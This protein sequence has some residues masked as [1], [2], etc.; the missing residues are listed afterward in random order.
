MTEPRVHISASPH[1]HSKHSKSIS[2]IMLWVVIALLP[3]TIWGII[4]FGIK[5][6]LVV[7]VSVVTAVVVEMLCDLL[8]KRSI[9]SIKDFSAVVTGLLVGLNLSSEV[10]LYVAI[11]AS[12]FAIAVCKMVFGGIGQNF[13]NPA[14][15]G[16]AFVMFS[17]TSLVNQYATPLLLQS[18]A[19]ADG[20]LLSGS[21][22]LSYFKNL[23]KTAATPVSSLIDS[24]YPFTD[25]AA[26]V[27][28]IFGINPYYV[29][30]F[31]G[32]IGGSIGEVSALFILVGAA[33]LFVKKIITWRIPVMYI[34]SF[35]ILTWIFGGVPQGAGLFTGD[36]IWGVLT[37]GLLLGAFFMATDMV[38]TPMSN[39][40]H[41]IFG[42]GC[43]FFT[44][45]FR[46]F[47][48]LSEG[49]CISILLMNV[50]TPLIDKYVNTRVFGTTKKKLLKKK[51]VA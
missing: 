8:M 26:G 35:F 23:P 48:S 34:G 24:T 12:A 46:T 9:N 37:G 47:A 42:L 4:A 50:A 33:I 27:L 5:A 10:P 16:R 22:P 29:D 49:V 20:I 3:T 14:L 45:L 13:I 31:I 18:K 51:E 39:K 30:A 2:S 6:L 7:L 43:G 28:D 19:G 38:T 21:T 1:I 36:P 40:G 15:G 17:F 44:F 25:F 41:I 11:I 32:N